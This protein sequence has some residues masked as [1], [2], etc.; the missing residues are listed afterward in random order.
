MEWWIVGVVDDLSDGGMDESFSSSYSN[1]S[2]IDRYLNTHTAPHPP[3]APLPRSNVAL[4]LRREEHTAF[5]GIY[6]SRETPERSH[7]K[8][9]RSEGLWETLRLCERA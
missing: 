8:A 3:A 4:S 7:A 5:A 6:T 1:S 2:S 9:Q